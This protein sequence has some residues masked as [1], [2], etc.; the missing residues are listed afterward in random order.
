[1]NPDDPQ[2]QMYWNAIEDLHRQERELAM[3]RKQEEPM[4]EF[5]NGDDA[6]DWIQSKLTKSWVDDINPLS[7]ED[8]AAL[9]ETH[10]SPKAA[11]GT[12]PS[13]AATPQTFTHDSAQALPSLSE[14]T[15]EDFEKMFN[16]ESS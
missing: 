2:D 16:G 11:S 9:K 3:T 5:E 13:V 15:A 1:M 7:P 10:K 12:V 14:L 6:Y 4:P 8:E